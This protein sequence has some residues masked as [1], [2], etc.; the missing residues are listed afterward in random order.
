MRGAKDMKGLCSGLCG[1]SRAKTRSESSA[2]SSGAV[3]SFMFTY[4]VHFGAHLRG[5][6]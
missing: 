5:A 6:I 2:K 4:G 3:P 1:L